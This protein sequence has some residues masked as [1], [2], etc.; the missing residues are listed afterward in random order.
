FQ[1]NI[2][3][4]K[5]TLE[6]EIAQNQ[7]PVPLQFTEFW[8]FWNVHEPEEALLRAALTVAPFATW[9]ATWSVKKLSK[10]PNVNVAV[11]PTTLSVAVNDPCVSVTG[12]AMAVPIITTITAS[13]TKSNVLFI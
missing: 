5:L 3:P 6:P 4:L 11:L 7:L 9:M 2:R 8:P 10:P 1:V 12:S 13:A